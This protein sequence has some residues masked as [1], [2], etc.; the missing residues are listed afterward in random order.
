VATVI[1]NPVA[2][3]PAS[4]EA[5]PSLRMP[6][7]R[8]RPPWVFVLIAVV[9]LGA[10]AAAIMRAWSGLLS[11]PVAT[12][13]SA[14]GRI[15]GREVTL[16][17]KAIQGRVKRLLVDEGQVVEKGQLL[18][19]L[20]VQQLEA[21][22]AAARSNV[23]TLEAQIEQARRDV[24]YTAKNTAASITAAD[25][26]LS[27]AEA[28]AVRAEAV[29]INA[30]NAYERTT[31]LFAAGAVSKQ[32][33]DQAE[34]ALRTSEADVAAAKKD[35]VRAEANVAL[36]RASAD[37]IGLK[38][39]QVRA[40]EESRRAATARLDEARA[41][42]AERFILAPD[43]GTIV[44][45][46]VEVGDVV[47]GGTPVFQV[48]DMKRLYLKVYIP[49]PDIGKLRLGQVAEIRVDAFPNRR[50]T[51]RI[52]KIYDQ[53]EFTPKNVETV[54]ERLKLVFGVELALDNADGVLKPGMPAD[55]VISVE[56]ASDD[57]HGDQS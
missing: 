29:L 23:A 4:R 6:A 51:A 10:A 18:A 39:Q 33:A 7:A 28:Q 31:A 56:A 26:A 25:A 38:E 21:Q 52:S 47:S 45:R 15:E 43:H 11:Q 48:V 30:R 53:A 55:C 9:V 46:P 17:T 12:V 34:M 50:F 16:A 3:P 36:A 24:A 19:E 44:S 40:L 14:S 42:L 13:L 35:V 5:R 2:N 37:A 57:G 54:E 27:A 49:E 41:N 20:D 1:D 8:N 32:D 22:A